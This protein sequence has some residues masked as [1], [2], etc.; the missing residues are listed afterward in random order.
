MG[1]IQQ[2]TCTSTAQKISLLWF[3]F[4]LGLNLIFLCFWVWYYYDYI[5]SLKQR[6][7]KFQ[8]R[9]KLNHNIYTTQKSKCKISALSTEC[10][11]ACATAHTILALKILTSTC[12]VRVGA[13][14]NIVTV[15]ELCMV[16]IRT[17]LHQV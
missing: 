3:N 17:Q 14:V 7:I 9:I 13:L 15:K 10:S 8:P 5:T 11:L 4:V 12:C 6:K 16:Q 2:G 1:K